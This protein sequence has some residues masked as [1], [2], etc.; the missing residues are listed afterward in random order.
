MN[1]LKTF[2]KK[3][4][5]P[6]SITIYLGSTTR[7]RIFSF[8]GGRWVGRDLTGEMAWDGKKNIFNITSPL[9]KIERLMK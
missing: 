1:L 6:E 9:C 7:H 5:K 3:Y 4:G 8:R 2:T